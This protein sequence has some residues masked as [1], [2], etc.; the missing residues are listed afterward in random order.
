MQMPE[1]PEPALARWL[2]HGLTSRTH[3]VLRLALEEHLLPL[4]IEADALEAEPFSAIE[5]GHGDAWLVRPRWRPEL[6]DV[7]LP[8]AG[9]F[10]PLLDHPDWFDV[11][12]DPSGT[13]SIDLA[14]GARGEASA[15]AFVSSGGQV[16]LAARHVLRA[17]QEA[18]RFI[19]AAAGLILANDPA[20]G[21]YARG[22]DR[23]FCERV[24][25]LVEAGKGD[26][27]P[28]PAT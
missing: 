13:L 6:F 8:V 28:A 21:L 19:F 18:E 5:S 24:R 10:A 14:A 15:R 20:A 3:P 11:A 26:E 22:D 9:A 23:A 27:T 17:A 4:G 16:W 25:E 1:S 12:V 2:A 7:R